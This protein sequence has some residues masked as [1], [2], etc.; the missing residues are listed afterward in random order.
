M[1]RFA[2]V[3]NPKRDK[4]DERKKQPKPL[5]T[6]LSV[7]HS[8]A[9]RSPSSTFSTPQL[10]IASDPAHSSAS[11]S[12][13]N[14]VI[15]TP[16]EELLRVLPNA[17]T[18]SSWKSWIGGKRSNSLKHKHS[19]PSPNRELPDWHTPPFLHPPPK[20]P[21][22]LPTPPSHADDS[23]EDESE[24]SLDNDSSHIHS[25]PTLQHL[26]AQAQHNFQTLVKNSL[27]PPLPV[28]PFVQHASGPIFPRSCNRTNILTSQ[29]PVRISMFRQRMLRRLQSSAL[30]SA[31]LAAILPIASKT[32]IPVITHPPSDIDISRPQKSTKIFLASPG[33]RRWITRP[34]FEDRYMVY[35]ATN[36]G[37]DCRPVSA[38]SLAIA[39]LEYPEHFD[40]MVNPDFEHSSLHPEKNLDDPWSITEPTLSTQ[41][42]AIEPPTVL[43]TES[44]AAEQSASPWRN[45]YT[46]VP[47]PLRN[48][49]SPPPPSTAA[50]S[51]KEDLVV[52]LAAKSTVKR[53]VRFAE[54]D[55]EDG[56][57]LHIV[58]MKKKKEE[59][60]LFLRKEQLKRA[61]EE[62]QEKLQKE[63]EALER[64]QRRVQKE[65]EKKETDKALYAE[66]VLAARLRRET[67]RAGGTND[68][69]NLLVPS[70][71][72]RVSERNMPSIES[73]RYSSR[74][75]HEATPSVSIPRR[76]ASD[77]H[78]SPSSH[79]HHHY[80]YTPDSS[81]G[82]SQPPSLSHSPVSYSG[83][84]IHSRPQSTY[85]AR[86]TSS[87][88]V[89][90]QGGSRRNSL[91]PAAAAAAGGGSSPYHR[92]PMVASHPTWSGSN[93][94]LHRQVPP[95]PL[96]PDY[97]H[98]M[99]LLPPTA[100]F[101][102]YA[103]Y[104]RRSRNSS[105]SP[106]STSSGSRRGSFNS[107]NE[108]V[109]QVPS[110][111]PRT[112][113]AA[114]APSNHATSSR[115]KRPTHERRSS[116]DSKDTSRS[117]TTQ[118]QQQQRPAPT[119]S[120]S[121]PNLTR[122]RPPLPA[123]MSPQYLQAPSPWSALPTHNGQ[124]PMMMPPSP[125]T[126]T[127]YYTLPMPHMRGINGGSTNGGNNQWNQTLLS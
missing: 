92:P 114:K 67:V 84:G 91:T 3:F 37:I 10:S 68:S 1:R 44:H 116:G 65:K 51:K 111:N 85:S 104:D 56:I 27:A 32:I 120:R 106:A 18:K 64:E 112:S 59:K 20:K 61:K 19:G 82:S 9:A 80:T 75:P 34:C 42:P 52:S 97:V 14:S 77:S 105:S 30:T 88:D 48:Q 50:S 87:E 126:H 22:R 72:S 16:D 90:Q 66:T 55:D 26:P 43:A 123:T 47:S 8:P 108:R 38:S 36:T 5:D 118:S 25:P 7:P 41:V 86:S 31:E 69:T 93:T 101:M 4:H 58:R 21:P 33:I 45:S 100:P 117:R 99:P 122:G 49:H 23:D 12:G 17:T 79:S 70:P 81:P 119:T 95:M 73:R 83:L 60:A 11:S 76:G 121:Q 78:L 40:V 71:S 35:L 113:S 13:S 15:H 124:I 24:E 102:K 98:D 46:V 89:R 74:L 96:L 125:Y 29:S 94:S 57:P 2:S 109:D 39:A 53:V 103:S 115:G 110:Q 63:Q 62:E 54:D 28:S 107:S 6:T 127:Q